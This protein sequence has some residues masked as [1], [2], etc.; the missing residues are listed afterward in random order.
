MADVVDLWDRIERSTAVVPKTTPIEREKKEKTPEEMEAEKR[1]RRRVILTLDIVSSLFWFYAL[2]KIF[3]VDLDETL[4]SRVAP[5]HENVLDYR[6]FFYLGLLV[7]LVWKR[8]TLLWVVLYVLAFPL[9]VFVWKIPWF[10]IKRRSWAL[11]LGTLQAVFTALSDFRYNLT[12][13]FLALVAA[14]LIIATSIRALL[15]CS[16]VYLGFLVANSYVR[17]LRKTFAGSSFLRVQRE[18]I[19]KL[20]ESRPVR[21]FTHMADEYKRADVEIYDA[22]QLNQI[23]SSISAGIIINKG[24]YFWAYQLERYRRD[25]SPSTVFASISYVWLLLGTVLGFTLINEAV[26]KLDADQYA[27]DGGPS[28]ISWIVYSVATMG[29][30]DGGGIAA[31]GDWAYAVQLAAMIAGPTL[32]ATFALNFVLT[33]KRERDE[34]ALRDLVA[35]LKQTAR[36]QDRRFKDEWAVSVDEAHERLE[37]LG[38]GLGFI[39]RWVTSSIPA[40]FFEPSGEAESEDLI[41]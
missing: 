25:Y 39:V 8:K 9:L 14:T 29:L 21:F 3:V 31:T 20:V 13:K 16:A 10:F 5:G 19:A 28:F 37:D 22:T 17:L 24:L 18:S 26:Y 27:T 35:T 6:I 41:T 4:I 34:S 32:L 1:K 38:A 11:F 40:E 30:S 7:V 36:E 12:S 15:V 33:Y 23:T 2:A